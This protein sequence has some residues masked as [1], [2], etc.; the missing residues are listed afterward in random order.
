VAIAL[1]WEP[2]ADPDLPGVGIDIAEVTSHQET[3]VRYALADEE[4]R[5]LDA[6]AAGQLDLWFTRFWAAKEAVGKA[7]RTGLDGRPRQFAV[8]ATGAAELIVTA[9]GRT[10]RVGFAD[11]QNPPDLPPRRYAVAWTWGPDIASDRY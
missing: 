1:P 4:L 6:I 9:A 7:Q 2:G 8:R 3:T 5:L 11:A 10:Y